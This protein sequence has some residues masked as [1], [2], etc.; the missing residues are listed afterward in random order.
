MECL[1]LHSA[2]DIMTENTEK[3]RL[4]GV[5]AKFMDVRLASG[6]VAFPLSDLVQETGL[7][8]I[9]A[10]NQL[11]RLRGRIVRVSPRQQF[12]LIVGPEHRQMGAPPPAW[13]LDDYFGWL[14]HPYYL[15][16]QSA[17]ETYG[18]SPQAL[19]V[20]Q[21]MTDVPRREIEVGRIRVRFFVKRGVAKTPTQPLANAF[22]PIRVSTPTATAFDLIR[23]AQRLGGIERAVETLTPLLPLIR[24]PDLRKLLEVEDET[25]TAQRFGYV[26]EAAG[27]TRLAEIVHGWLPSRLALVPLIASKSDR[28]TGSMVERWRIL[29]NAGDLGL[30]DLTHAS[31]CPGA[32]GGLS[33]A[34]SPP[35][36]TGSA[37]L[38]G[39][40]RADRASE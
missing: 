13:W 12:F 35:G 8:V 24:V 2:N 5:A 33:A 26:L 18:S 22:A 32:L 39:H 31:G 38:S 23:Y 28:T 37:S 36:R 21:V 19:Q 17:A 25:A 4:A 6:S 34:K 3:P 9:A 16:L 7:S 20:T 11:L 40:D 1:T 30:C 10:R 15:A 29:N 14:G 27:M